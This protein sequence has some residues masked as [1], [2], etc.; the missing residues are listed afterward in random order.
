MC[1][2]I[3]L[4][5]GILSLLGCERTPERI[6]SKADREEVIGCYHSAELPNTKM[7]VTPDAIYF[8]GEKVYDRYQTLLSTKGIAPVIYVWPRLIAFEES[9][10]LEFKPYRGG[11]GGLTL[12]AKRAEGRLF[13]SL[14]TFEETSFPNG[15][16]R[17]FVRSQC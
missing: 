3:I 12:I 16:T 14:I 4:T 17:W 2:N 8:D 6:D 10:R 13:I 7:R 9:G 5:I 1:R 11:D 15:H